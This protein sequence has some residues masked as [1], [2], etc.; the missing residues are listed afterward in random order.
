MHLN[1]SNIRM[2]HAVPDAGPLDIFINNQ[3]VTS[4]FEFKAIT[5]Y[6][7]AQAGSYQFKICPQGQQDVVLVNETISIKEDETLTLAV[8]GFSHVMDVALINDMPETNINPE[9]SYIRFVHAYP[10]TVDVDIFLGP[11]KKTNSFMYREV[12]PLFEE[13]PGSYSFS[14]LDTATGEVKFAHPRLA[15]SP[16]RKYAGYIL[17]S[18]ASNLE[19]LLSLEE[20]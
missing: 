6:Y 4:R 7:K 3:L 10:S 8:L 15:L 18:D 1:N 2:L 5:P 17:G 11:N 9:K 13:E 19:M 12:S 16:G 20:V 14:G